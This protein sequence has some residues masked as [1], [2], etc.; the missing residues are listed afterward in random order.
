MHSLASGNV[1]QQSPVINTIEIQ[2]S[3]QPPPST[4]AQQTEHTTGTR[5]SQHQRCSN[6]NT[7]RPA[8][9]AQDPALHWPTPAVSKGLGRAA[10]AASYR[11]SRFRTCR[12]V[13]PHESQCTELC[14]EAVAFS[15]FAKLMFSTIDI[16][17]LKSLR[18]CIK[19]QFK[20]LPSLWLRRCCIAMNSRS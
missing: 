5:R 1:N 15:S 18:T 19:G 10:R 20:I 3:S 16:A 6:R 9:R 8:R 7:H 12:K 17:A 13:L 14:P 11:Q 4:G 2:W